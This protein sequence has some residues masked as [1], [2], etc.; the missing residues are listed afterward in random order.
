[1]LEKGIRISVKNIPYEITLS[2]TISYFKHNS[3]LIP[4]FMD[5]YSYGNAEIAVESILDV[6]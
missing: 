4:L 1:M 2:D 3:Y 6:C 5:C